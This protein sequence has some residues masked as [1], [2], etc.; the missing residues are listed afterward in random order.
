MRLPDNTMVINEY[1]TPLQHFASR[2]TSDRCVG[3]GVIINA[4]DKC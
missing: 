3:L 1:T 4:E 2:K